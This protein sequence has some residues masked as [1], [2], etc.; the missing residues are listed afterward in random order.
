MHIYAYSCTLYKL[1]NLVEDL[2]TS[3]KTLIYHNVELK[4]SQ[5]LYIGDQRTVVDACWS[6]IIEVGLFDACYDPLVAL[7]LEY[8]LDGGAPRSYNWGQ[9]LIGPA[10]HTKLYISLFLLT[11]CIWSY[12]LWSPRNSNPQSSHA[13]S[14][15]EKAKRK[16]RPRPFWDYSSGVVTTLIFLQSQLSGDLTK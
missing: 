3:P 13:H 2:L 4:P 6:T 15:F 9:S 7:G 8:V 1:S 12:L 14:R 10:I 11:I 16:C 5:G